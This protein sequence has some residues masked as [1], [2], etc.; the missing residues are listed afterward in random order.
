MTGTRSTVDHS[1]AQTRDH[2]GTVARVPELALRP[3][4]GSK[5]HWRGSGTEGG[6]WRSWVALTRYRGLARW[7][8]NNNQEAVAE[9]LSGGSARARRG[10]E[11][12]RERCSEDR[13]RHRPFIGGG[14]RRAPRLHGRRQCLGLKVPVIRV[15]RGEGV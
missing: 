10:E 3:L 9:E 13:A 12:S 1:A 14:W 7:P 11:K 8:G 5:A 2:Q 15:M 6:G 4:L